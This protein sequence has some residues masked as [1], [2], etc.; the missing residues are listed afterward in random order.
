VD[1]SDDV[2]AISV[3]PGFGDEIFTWCDMQIDE[4]PAWIT[5]IDMT[6]EGQSDTASNFQIF[7]YNQVTT[8]W[9]GPLATI[10]A[11]AD[12]DVTLTGTIAASCADYI[13]GGGILTWGC[14]Q[15]TNSQLIRCDY[16]EAVISFSAPPAVF[17]MEYD[18]AASPSHVLPTIGGGPPPAPSIDLTGVG[19]DT[20]VFVSCPIDITGDV[21]TIFDDSLHPQGDGGTT[22][23]YAQ[24]YDNMNKEWR[25]YS[26]VKPP[27]LNDMDILDNTYGVWLHITANGGD[28]ELTF[29]IAGSYPGAPVFINLY[30]GWNLVGYP[31]A[32]PLLGGGLPGQA[33]LVAYYNAV[34][35]YRITDAAP[36]TV[37]FQE[38]DAYWVRVVSDCIWTVNP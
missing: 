6:F 3:D 7:A 35:P 11:A 32:T 26:T 19:P 13:S 37:M 16:L 36:G 21:A 17:N 28:Q 12:T 38:D 30:T 23:D 9:D 1:T 33:D 15:T 22:W 10:A 27:A 34:A 31:S 24:W 25:T 8:S 18:Y 20:W 4:N 2:R 29:G 5:Q 14:Y